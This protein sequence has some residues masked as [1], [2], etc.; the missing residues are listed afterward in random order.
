LLDKLFGALFVAAGVAL[1]FYTLL[2]MWRAHQSLAWPILEAEVLDNSIKKHRGRG[3]GHEPVVRYRYQCGS[4]VYEGGTLVFS[5]MS[6][7]GSREEAE[8]FLKQLPVGARIP[9][10][11]CPGRSQLSVIKPGIEFAWYWFPIT[12]SLLCILGGLSTWNKP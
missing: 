4:K 1:F 8:E 5:A 2:Q 3:Q 6:V 7:T 10:S 12:F 11:V 9:V